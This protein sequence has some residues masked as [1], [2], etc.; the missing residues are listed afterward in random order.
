VNSPVRYTPTLLKCWSILCETPPVLLVG[1][2][3]GAILGL[4]TPQWLIVAATCAVL[5]AFVASLLSA[6]RHVGWRC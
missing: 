3:H 6:G 5:P 2:A 4:A 1:Y